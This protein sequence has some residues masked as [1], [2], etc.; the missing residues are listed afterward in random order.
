MSLEFDE[1][2]AEHLS[3][4]VCELMAEVARPTDWFRLELVYLTAGNAREINL[5]GVWSDG[6]RKIDTTP[7][8]IEVP[9]QELRRMMYSPGEG[10][11]FL[12]R[13][14]VEPDLTRTIIYDFDYDPKFNPEIDSMEWRRELDEFPRGPEFMPSWLEERVA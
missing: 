8:G 14:Y 3:R 6:I 1:A 9:L 2:R 11:W 7:P 12:T 4:E 5:F 10:T 13:Y